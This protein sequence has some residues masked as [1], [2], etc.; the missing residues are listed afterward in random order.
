MLNKECDR[1]IL[2]N[3]YF[4]QNKLTFFIFHYIYETQIFFFY[5]LG[6]AQPEP[7]SKGV[8]GGSTTGG[9]P[10]MSGHSSQHSHGGTHPYHHFLGGKNLSILGQH[11]DV[12][13]D[14]IFLRMLE[15]NLCRY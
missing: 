6:A 8:A 2:K 5:F 10:Q 13:H 7:P 9:L 3:A 15:N 14:R 12:I 11:K 4:V 1:Y